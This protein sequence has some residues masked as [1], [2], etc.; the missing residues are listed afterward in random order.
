MHK[1]NLRRLWLTGLLMTVPIGLV[2]SQSLNQRDA[3]LL[4]G[5]ILALAFLA[6]LPPAQPAPAGWSD[7]ITGLPLR[8]KLVRFLEDRL[9]E[10]ADQPQ[11]VCVMIIGIDRFRMV[12]ERFS[13]EDTNQILSI[14]ARRVRGCLRDVD[15]TAR[16]DGPVFG[17]AIRLDQDLE[18]DTMLKLAGRIQRRIGGRIRMGKTIVNISAS[19][20]ICL[21]NRLEDR[22]ASTLLQAGNAALIEAQRHGPAAIRS[23]S[24]AMREKVIRRSDLEREVVEALDK[25]EI[26]AHFQPQI[27]TRTGEITGV[28]TLARWHH[29]ERGLVPPIEFLPAIENAGM[30]DKLC[31]LMITEGLRAL[32]GWDAKGLNIPKVGINFS[33]FELGSP[34]IVEQIASELERHGVAANRLVIEVLED[35]VADKSDDIIIRNLASL[36]RL[37]CCL[38]LDDFGTGHASITSIR[39]FAVQRIKIDRTFITGIDE[40][41]EQQRMVGAILTMANELKVDTLAE[42]VETRG[43]LDELARLGCGHVQGYV[44]SRPMSFEDTARWIS[45][46]RSENGSEVRPLRRV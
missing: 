8:D 41:A 44:L 11:D 34:K 9:T 45:S 46:Y 24:D 19:V 2:I 31:T 20:G 13:H 40:D 32:T 35:V 30:M 12:E 18:L 21:P 43:E 28:E 22:S 4:A 16:L 39:R 15:L 33:H 26:V 5:L 27:C 7:P 37:G 29:S 3:L 38:D 17:V 42:G 23:Y 36:A 14:T 1:R 10:Q 6:L 25:G